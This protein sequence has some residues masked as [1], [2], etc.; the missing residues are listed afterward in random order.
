[1]IFTN[2]RECDIIKT[3]AEVQTA[4]AN[5][6]RFHKGG[7]TMKLNVIGRKMNVYEETKELIAKKL[8]KLDKFFAEEGDATVTLSRKRGVSTMEVTINAAGTLFRSEQEAD[9]FREA[10]DRCVEI[11]ERQIRK[12]KTRLAKR[13]RTAAVPEMIAFSEEEEE[14]EQLIRTKEFSVKPMSVD[15][16]IMQMNLLGHD[17]FVFCDDQ[18]DKICVVYRRKDGNYGLIIPNKE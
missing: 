8:E 16:A 5:I 18:E 11:I 10:L 12:N 4:A 2:Q 17:F 1:M 3:V 15:E 9:D 14:E 7:T 6:Q 13:L